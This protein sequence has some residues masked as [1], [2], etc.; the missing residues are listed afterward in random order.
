MNLQ[1]E[2]EK[3]YVSSTIINYQLNK[4]PTLADSATFPQ[5]QMYCT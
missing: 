4:N 2:T 5:F 3:Q 1:A